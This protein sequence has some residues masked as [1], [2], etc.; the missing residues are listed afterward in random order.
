MRSVR[1]SKTF[2]F[3]DLNDG[4]FFKGVQVVFNDTM[5]N[6]KEIAKLGVGASII[7]KGK[8]VPTP[9]QKKKNKQKTSHIPLCT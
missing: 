8:L 7:V 1:D 5:A 3:I 9:N 4:T 6:F 2:G